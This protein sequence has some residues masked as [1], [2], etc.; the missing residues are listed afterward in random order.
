[1]VAGRSG[2]VLVVGVLASISVSTASEV[3]SVATSVLVWYAGVVDVD[4]GVDVD[5]D[6]TADAGV[7]VVYVEGRQNDK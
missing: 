1:M 6:A 7:Y 3:A 2:A 4:G 5:A